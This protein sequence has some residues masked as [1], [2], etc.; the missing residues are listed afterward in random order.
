MFRILMIVTLCTGI[1]TSSN[2]LEKQTYGVFGK[3][4]VAVNKNGLCLLT[5]LFDRRRGYFLFNVGYEKDKL[6]YRLSFTHRDFSDLP[7]GKLYP[8]EVVIDRPNWKNAAYAR[9]IANKVVSISIGSKTG[10]SKSFISGNSLR[11]VTAKKSYSIP[12]NGSSASFRIYYRCLLESIKT[13]K[14][15]GNPFEA[16]NFRV[17]EKRVKNP[18]E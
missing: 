18:F 7:K 17:R 4:K 9:V 15:T 13:K 10:F 5:R 1:A 14:N 3:W 6:V 11:V 16:D 2:A 8:V 12:L